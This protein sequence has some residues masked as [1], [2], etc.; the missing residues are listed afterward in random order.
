[1][2]LYEAGKLGARCDLQ[3]LGGPVDGLE[4]RFKCVLH[5]VD[6]YEQ[7]TVAKSGSK[8][9]VRRVFGIPC[10]LGMLR[11]TQLA[12]TCGQGGKVVNLQLPFDFGRGLGMVKTAASCDQISVA[13]R[14]FKRFASGGATG[15]SLVKRS[16][17][18]VVGMRRV[19][20]MRPVS[21]KV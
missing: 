5:R 2:S 7:K 1:M 19:S 16:S 21:P 13:Y 8:V 6:F 17:R 9:L 3:G 14:A 4:Y 18:L 10:S 12:D 15:S 20:M 11:Q